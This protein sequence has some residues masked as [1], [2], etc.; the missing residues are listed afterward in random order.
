MSEGVTPLYSNLFSVSILLFFVIINLVG[1]VM[2]AEAEN[3]IVV[4]KLVALVIFTAVSLLFIHPSNLAIGRAPAAINIFY[5]VTQISYTLA[6]DGDLPESYD[7]NIFHNTEGL[8]ISA[9]LILPMILLFNLGQIVMG[10]E[11]GTD[12]DLYHVKGMAVHSSRA[13]I[14]LMIDDFDR[15]NRLPMQMHA[16]G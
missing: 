13:G 4:I 16:A 11:A 10:D 14:G 1:A 3:I 7:Y 2:V 5:A 9:V 15:E 8:I 12:T 6:K